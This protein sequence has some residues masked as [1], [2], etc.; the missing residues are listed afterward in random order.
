MSR[1]NRQVGC[2]VVAV[3]LWACQGEAVS[4][5][6]AQPASAQAQ[7]S[8]T[9]A[10]K[11]VNAYIQLQTRLSHDDVAGA[12]TAFVTLQSALKD[13]SLDLDAEVS[14]KM[15]S[16]AAQGAAAKEIED[17]RAAFGAVSDA[18]L[19]Y[20][21]KSTNPLS[22]SLTVAHCP[23]ALDNKGAKWLQLGDK[24]ENPYFGAS[25][26]R[27]GSVEKTVKPGKSP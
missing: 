1:V 6:E 7:S 17:A 27:C 4:V 13:K 14:K 23:M 16:A 5:S 26:L 22:T 24:I 2:W 20:L 8:G 9:P 19:S 15:S 25:M 10:Q 21:A 12:K 3:S 11:L 18:M